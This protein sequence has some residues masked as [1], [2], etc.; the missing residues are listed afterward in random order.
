MKSNILR[1]LILMMCL[2]VVFN[3]ISCGSGRTK[4]AVPQ[5]IESYRES[6]DVLR[7][8]LTAIAA[9]YPGEIGIAVIVNGHDTITVNDRD[10]YPLMSV[11]KLHQAI[12]LCHEFEKN[13]IS[14]DTLIDID[15]STLNPNTWSPMLKENPEPHFK[16]S[17]KDLMR[18][19]LIK[20]DNNASNL[21]FDRLVD[22]VRTDN[23][24]STLVPRN[25]FRISVR[26][27]AMGRDHSLCYS[28]HSSPSSTAILLD[29]LFNDSIISPSN[30]RFICNVLSECATGTDR[31]S[32]PLSDKNGVSVAHKTGSGYRNDNGLLIAHNDAAHI[33]LPDGRHYTLVVFVKDFAGDEKAASTVISRISAIT[34]NFITS[35]T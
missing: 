28:N 21:M 30:Q 25:G 23:F 20:S 35:T 33:M 19:T 7:D 17:A 4:R 29:K 6:L 9:S 11:F 3:S 16:L 34:Y 1:F 14:I 13:D 32:A 10:V 2:P 12:A 24:I 5:K 8:S 27:E 31:I 18:Y 26:E 22:V 15:R